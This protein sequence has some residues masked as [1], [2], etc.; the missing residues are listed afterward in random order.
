MRRKYGQRVESMMASE[1]Y[2]REMD[3]AIREWRPDFATAPRPNGNAGECVRESKPE[4]TRLPGGCLLY[5]LTP[6]VPPCAR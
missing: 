2:L 3:R 6:G 4:A 5:R 1:H